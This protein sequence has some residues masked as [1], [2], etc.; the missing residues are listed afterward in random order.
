[1]TAPS[2][3][4]TRDEDLDALR[5]AGGGPGAGAMDDTPV[6]SAGLGGAT[7]D[8]DGLTNAALTAAHLASDD[9]LD[10]VAEPL[11]V[12]TRVTVLTEVPID[13]DGETIGDG[14][15]DPDAVAA[16]PDGPIDGQQRWLMIAE[17]AYLNAAQ[18]DF[19]PGREL[20]DWLAAERA[21]D[22]EIAARTAS[23]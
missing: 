19:A 15:A 12:A 20:D 8:G 11:V 17:L 14:G 6:T 21:V 5:D 9:A 23:R 2:P 7:D 13:A 1:M 22:A 10:G 4:A 16:L 18:R 3:A